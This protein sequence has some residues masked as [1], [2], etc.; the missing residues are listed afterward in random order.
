MGAPAP[1]YTIRVDEGFHTD[2]TNFI[3]DA[4]LRAGGAT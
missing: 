1:E 4:L 2:Q 3:E